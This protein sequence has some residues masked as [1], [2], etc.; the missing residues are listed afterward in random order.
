MEYS[1]AVPAGGGGLGHPIVST[2][3]VLKLYLVLVS[4]Y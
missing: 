2:K 3:I 4:R 1:E